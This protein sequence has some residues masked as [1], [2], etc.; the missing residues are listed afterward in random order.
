MYSYP[1]NNPPSKSE[2]TGNY[3]RPPSLYLNSLI[4]SFTFS[5]KITAQLKPFIFYTPIFYCLLKVKFDRKS[6]KLSPFHNTICN[7]MNVR[8]K[9]Q[10]A[11]A[12]I[13]TFFKSFYP[14]KSVVILF[15]LLLATTFEWIPVNNV[16]NKN[17]YYYYLFICIYFVELHGRNS[18]KIA[19]RVHGDLWESYC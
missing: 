14:F 19:N 5:D 18:A 11:N 7:R 13:I 8:L 16:F 10:N 1:N 12:Q 15:T 4:T 3:E 2:S 17:Y 9:I 6:D